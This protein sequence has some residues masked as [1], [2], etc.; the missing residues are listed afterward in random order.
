[1]LT[2]KAYYFKSNKCLFALLMLIYSFIYFV[3]KRFTSYQAI[4]VTMIIFLSDL[5]GKIEITSKG[6][7]AGCPLANRCA[8]CQS[9]I[10]MKSIMQTSSVDIWSG[11][12]DSCRDSFWESIGQI[13][14][15]VTVQVRVRLNE[16]G[17]F[18]NTTIRL[19]N[20]TLSAVSL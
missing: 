14:Q 12:G 9:V 3:F 13:P 6:E 4:L 17:L 10:N 15:T 20:M 19:R 11:F 5:S 16:H 1:M 18:V 8:C 2:I 7:W